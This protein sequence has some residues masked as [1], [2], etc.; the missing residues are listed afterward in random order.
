MDCRVRKKSGEMTGVIFDM[1]TLRQAQGERNDNHQTKPLILSQS[2]DLP[3][4]VNPPLILSLSKDGFFD[5]LRVCHVLILVCFSERE[6][7]ASEGL[8]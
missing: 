1:L 8:T 3:E 4:P 6:T 7:S 5:L 2:K